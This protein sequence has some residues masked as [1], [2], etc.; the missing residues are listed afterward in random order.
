MQGDH[1]RQRCRTICGGR[2][3]RVRSHWSMVQPC[4]QLRQQRVVDYPQIGRF[5]RPSQQVSVSTTQPG[6]SVEH[7]LPLLPP[8]VHRY[9]NQHGSATATLTV[10]V[11][12]APPSSITHTKFIHIDKGTAMTNVTLSVSGGPIA[13][14]SVPQRSQQACPQHSEWYNQWNT[15]HCHFLG[16]LHSYSNQRRWKQ[17]GDSNIRVNDIAPST[18]TYSQ[19]HLR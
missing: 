11:N 15:N 7:L 3:R 13:S 19:V 4:Q 14:W 5:H 2:I 10:Q 16:Y 18:I 6:P 8:N 17:H 12:M 9:S 1:R